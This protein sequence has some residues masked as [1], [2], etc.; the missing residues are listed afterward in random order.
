MTLRTVGPVEQYAAG[1]QAA[2]TFLALL[3]TT[4][5]ARGDE[6]HATVRAVQVAHGEEGFRAFAKRIQQALEDVAGDAKS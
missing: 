2:E 3:S 6:F 4:A 1:R 5:Y